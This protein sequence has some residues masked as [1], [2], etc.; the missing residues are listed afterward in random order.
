MQMTTEVR[1]KITGCLTEYLTANP[2]TGR[3]ALTE[4]VLAALALSARTLRDTSPSGKANIYRSYIGTVLTELTV[5][6]K[7]KRVGK[8][9]FLVG[10]GLVIVRAA[11][12]RA[13]ILLLLSARPMRKNEIFEALVKHF[14]TDKTK[15][16]TDDGILRSSAG[17]ALADLTRTGVV[18]AENGIFRLRVKPLQKNDGAPLPREAFEK[19]FFERLHERGGAFFEEFLAGLLEKYFLMTGREVL[20]LDVTGGSEDGGVDIVAETRD[21]LGFC[22]RVMVQAKCRESALATE[23]EVREFFGAMTAQGGTRGIFATTSAFHPGAVRFLNSI[24]H[25]VG[26]DRE[27]IFEIAE[28]TAY[29]LKK[30]KNGYVLDPTI[31]GV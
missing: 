9:Y 1:K 26:I 14:G 12:C 30:T 27:K 15:T 17:S 24:P 3:E 16:E 4:G 23:K 29:G 31:F 18:E 25:C 7:V 10:E 19:L 2:G 11:E 22:D 6:G 5:E 13:P 8:G 20:L 28:K 21:G